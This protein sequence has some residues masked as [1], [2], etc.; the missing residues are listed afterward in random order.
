MAIAGLP[1]ARRKL[2]Y[3][4]WTEKGEEWLNCEKISPLVNTLDLPR[5]VGVVSKFLQ[6]GKEKVLGIDSLQFRCLNA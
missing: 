2:K 4:G 3:G 5:R 6:R 1:E